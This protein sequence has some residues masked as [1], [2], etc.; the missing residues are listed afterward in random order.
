M[1]TNTAVGVGQALKPMDQDRFPSFGGLKSF[2]ALALTG[3][4]VKAAERLNVCASAVSHQVKTLERELSVRLVENKGGKLRLT[5]QGEQYFNAIKGPLR[6]LLQATDAIRSN[7]GRRRVSLTLT[8]SFA[9]GWLLPQ[10]QQFQLKHPDIELDLITT[11]RV[12]DLSRDNI[13]LAIRRGRGNWPDYEVQPLM[14]EVLVPV[15]APQ[16]LKSRGLRTVE[17][18]LKATR[19]LVNT[20]MAHEWDTYCEARS[21]PPPPAKSRFNLETY[22]L[23]IQAARDGLGV[24]LGRK[25]LVD[26]LLQSGDLVTLDGDAGHDLNAYYVVRLPSEMGMAVRCVH[27]WLLAQAT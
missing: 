23:T 7:P 19:V 26:K 10:L 12:L 9:A 18:A 2:Y 1:P 14:R 25:P 20:T 17:Q 21:I 22:E 15:V 16:V 13:D 27:D 11:T 4:A 8:P 6:D 3:S 5:T 24:T